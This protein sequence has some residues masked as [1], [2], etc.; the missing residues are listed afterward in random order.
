MLGEEQKKGLHFK[1]QQTSAGS[2]RVVYHK[3]LYTAGFT[4]KTKKDVFTSGI[5]IFKGVY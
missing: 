5:H 3:A 2:I 1:N 4:M